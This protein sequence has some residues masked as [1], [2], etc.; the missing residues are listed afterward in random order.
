MK[1]NIG[2]RFLR[3]FD[4]HFT[5]HHKHYKLF[6]RNNIKISYSCMQNMASI[7]QKHNTNLLK[8]PVASTAKECS[9]RQNFSCPLA[10]KCLS[11]CLVYH[12]QVDRSDINQTT[13][14]YDTC[15]KNFKERYNNNIASF[16]NKSKEKSTELSKYIWELKNSIMNYDLKWSIAYKAHP[17]TG[18]TR[19]YDLCLT[20]KP[21][22]MK[23]DPESLLNTRDKFVSKCTLRFFKKK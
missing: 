9:C 7:I 15:K 23:A 5:K 11:E 19:K 16:R 22:I 12:A 1:T 14:Y 20:E 18:G 8:D 3:L 6:N 21:A 13:N 10:E 4:K 17:Y 2:K